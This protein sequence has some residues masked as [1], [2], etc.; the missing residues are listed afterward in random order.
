RFSA[1][2]SQL[3]SRIGLMAGLA[4]AIPLAIGGLTAVNAQSASESIAETAGDIDVPEQVTMLGKNDPNVRRATAVVNGQVVTGTDVD[5]RLAL[6][7]AANDSKV[8]PEE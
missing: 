4:L 5:Q 7:L 6:I 3:R 8:A 1:L 2:A